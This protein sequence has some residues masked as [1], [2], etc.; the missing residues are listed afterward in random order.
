MLHAWALAIVESCT[1]AVA[2]F[3]RLCGV[4]D[5]GC[6]RRAR[7]RPPHAVPPPAPLTY[8]SPA[9]RAPPRSPT[10]VILHPIFAFGSSL[11]NEAFFVLFLTWMIWELDFE[12]AR[13]SMLCWAA[14]CVLRARARA[15]AAP[16]P[17][18]RTLTP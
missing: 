1:P 9:P 12:V 14:L 2:R 7:T 10:N 4:T 5:N 6:G 15:R 18:A 3:Q 13:R 8:P 17:R 16:R 11:G